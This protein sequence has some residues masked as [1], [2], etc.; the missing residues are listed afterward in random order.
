[1][2]DSSRRLLTVSIFLVLGPLLTAALLGAIVVRKTPLAAHWEA[3]AIQSKVS[4]NVQVESVS[5]LRPDLVKL[6]GVKICDPLTGKPILFCP[7]VELHYDLPDWKD[8]SSEPIGRLRKCFVDDLIIELDPRN[9]HEGIDRIIKLAIELSAK[10][11]PGREIDLQFDIANVEFKFV[12][13]VPDESYQLTMLRGKY[14]AKADNNEILF[15]FNMRNDVVSEP[16][17]FSL[18]KA[19][20]AE[21][22]LELSSG[23]TVIPGKLLTLFAPGFSVFGEDFRFSG[24]IRASFQ[25]KANWLFTLEKTTIRDVD[26]QTF[27]NYFTPYRASGR[28]D[29]SIKSAANFE[30]RGGE[31]RFINAK[32]WFGIQD[33]KIAKELMR[34][35]AE[36]FDLT[37][38]P[39][40]LAQIYRKPDPIAMFPKEVE[41]PI[42]E[43]IVLFDLNQAGAVFQPSNSTENGLIIAINRENNYYMPKNVE[44]SRVSYPELLHLLM[45]DNSE[46][47]PL[48]PHSQRV[49]NL[50]NLPPAK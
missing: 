30:I 24:T 20:E 18:K 32:G 23:K 19:H 1:M 13:T 49:I 7:T 42:K 16:I 46:L 43:A 6:N 4:R 35:I 3:G 47:V 50:L 26:L 45:P 39:R 21:A 5:Y 48:T 10:Q 11:V 15:M 34:K 17:T 12:G 33:G 2:Y 29:M 36:Q 38:Y 14:V 27:A 44:Q 40:H 9:K 8:V 31:M 28:L 41:L 22:L 25:N 37:P